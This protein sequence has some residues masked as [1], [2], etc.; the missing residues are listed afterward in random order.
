MIPIIEMQRC[1]PDQ[2]IAAQLRD[3]G[4]TVL[5]LLKFLLL[6]SVRC[7]QQALAELAVYVPQTGSVDQGEL[8]PALDFAD[9]LQG[10]L[11]QEFNVRHALVH[12][13]KVVHVLTHSLVKRGESFY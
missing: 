4:K 9:V 12:H 3:I 2:D 5:F 10:A 11:D 13:G 6:V 8:Q 7:T 1:S